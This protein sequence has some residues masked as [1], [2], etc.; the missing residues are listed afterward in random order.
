MSLN[1]AG[2]LCLLPFR[3]PKRRLTDTTSPPARKAASAS[4]G[5]G[6]LSSATAWPAFGICTSRASAITPFPILRA[7]GSGSIAL[8]SPRASSTGQRSF[9]SASQSV[10][11]VSRSCSLAAEQLEQQRVELGLEAAVAARHQAGACEAVDAPRPSGYASPNSW[12]YSATLS[13]A[14][15]CSLASPEARRQAAPRRGAG[16]DERER[17]H[18]LGVPRRRTASRRF[19]RA[20]GRPASARSR[21][22]ASNSSARSR[23]WSN[24]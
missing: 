24:R 7:T 4:S 13:Y 22:S 1:G 3:L 2:T 5:P 18:A 16:V 8:R 17:P 23:A 6:A 12:R 14:R 20:S 19:R 10:A 11:S 9:A 21:P 15:A